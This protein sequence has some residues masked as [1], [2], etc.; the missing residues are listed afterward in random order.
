MNHQVSTS[1]VLILAA[2]SPARSFTH[3]QCQNLCARLHAQISV[4]SSVQTRHGQIFIY[5]IIAA[6]AVRNLYRALAGA[7]AHVLLCM[8][9]EQPRKKK[10]E[11]H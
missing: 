10:Y 2:S 3:R 7:K 4:H 8:V 1:Q 5:Q 9:A 11:N 6:V